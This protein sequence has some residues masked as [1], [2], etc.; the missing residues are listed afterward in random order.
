MAR[1][2]LLPGGE[3]EVIK[4]YISIDRCR[5]IVLYQ[6]VADAAIHEGVEFLS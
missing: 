6:L 5:E 2:N 1:P 4:A 3:K